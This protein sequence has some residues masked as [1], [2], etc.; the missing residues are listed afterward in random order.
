MCRDFFKGFKPKY[1]AQYDRE[2]GLTSRVFLSPEDSDVLTY[3]A[4][5][6][7]MRQTGETNLNLDIINLLAFPQSK[8]LYQQLSKYPQEVIPAMD[9]VLKDM[10]LDVADMDRA[11]AAE[12]MEGDQGDIE[13]AEIMGRVYKVRPFGIASTNMRNLNP[14]G[15]L[16]FLFSV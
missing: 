14:T 6:R 5:F 7:R 2:N 12:G 11:A 9:Q 8:K 15:K 1:R 10:M 13:I 3:E 4:Y 16:S